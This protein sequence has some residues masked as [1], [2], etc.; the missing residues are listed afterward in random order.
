MHLKPYQRKTNSG[1]NFRCLPN[2]HRS[3]I[4][5]AEPA[6]RMLEEGVDLLLDTPSPPGHPVVPDVL[7][8]EV[9][10]DGQEDRVGQQLRLL[11]AAVRGGGEEQLDGKPSKC[12]GR[13]QFRGNV[14]LVSQFT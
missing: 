3:V 1:S 10:V 9:L 4:E 6:H 14:Y 12:C 7:G 13:T 5:K 2:L 11:L 8:L